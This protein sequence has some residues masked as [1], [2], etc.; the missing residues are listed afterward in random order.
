[1]QLHRWLRAGGQGAGALSEG[2]QGLERQTNPLPSCPS[3]CNKGVYCSKKMGK[4][5]DK[6]GKL[7]IVE[8]SEIIG[9]L[10]GRVGRGG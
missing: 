2:K 5:C 8:Y 6:F 1:M 9:C 4:L 10:P 7:S 3:S